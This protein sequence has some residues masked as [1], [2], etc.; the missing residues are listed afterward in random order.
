MSKMS[1]ITTSNYSPNFDTKKRKKREIKFIVF[2]YTGMKKEMQAIKRLTS[3]KSKVSTHYFIKNSGEILTIVPELYVAWHAGISNWRNFKSLN[4]YSIGIEINNP[5][6]DYKYKKYSNKQISSIVKLSRYLIKKYK[7][8]SNSILGHSDIAPDRK[9]DPGEK[10]PW[11][12]LARKK[13]GYWHNLNSDKL[14]KERNIKISGIDKFTFIKNMRKIGYPNK[15]IKNN[16]KFY[17]IITTSFQRRFRQELI[18]GII[19]KECLTI[20]KNLI[21]KIK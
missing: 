9:K 3:P 19:D 12:Y 6:H 17:K 18:N 13:I 10:F 4:K 16:I 21:K 20:S 15:I 14:S 2:H 5:G 8:R 1:L 7:I 11:R